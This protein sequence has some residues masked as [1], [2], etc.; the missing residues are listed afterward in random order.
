MITEFIKV[1]NEN[2]IE[3]G[4]LKEVEFDDKPIALAKFQDTIYAIDNIC[5]H[6]GGTLSEG[7]VVKGQV[8]CPR[9]G[10]RFDL[11]T[12]TVTRMPAVLA[13]GA[14]EVKIENGEVFVAIP[15]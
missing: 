10:A 4:K 7:D 8:Q 15:R 6:D 2:E 14:Y 11:K 9:H 3:E 1:C 12:G 13:I 5:T